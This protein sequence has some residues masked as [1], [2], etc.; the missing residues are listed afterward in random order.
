[1]WHVMKME[2]HCYF[3]FH[4]EYVRFETLYW[5]C[6]VIFDTIAMITIFCT[7]V[8]SVFQGIALNTEVLPFSK[9]RALQ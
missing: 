7:V 4:C 2:A 1:M 8:L 3:V 6:V 5:I 9:G